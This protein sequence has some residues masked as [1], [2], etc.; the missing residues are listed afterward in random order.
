M[1]MGSILKYLGIN[2]PMLNLYLSYVKERDS[3]VRN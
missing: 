3:D 1:V 2:G